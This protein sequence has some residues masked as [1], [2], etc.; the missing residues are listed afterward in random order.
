MTLGSPDTSTRRARSTHIKSLVAAFIAA[1]V[2]I[3]ES[4]VYGLTN[5]RPGRG[6]WLATYSAFFVCL[7]RTT[8]PSTCIL[9]R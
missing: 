7:G 1:L 5:P 3:M 4:L 8:K 2:C 6:H 9:P